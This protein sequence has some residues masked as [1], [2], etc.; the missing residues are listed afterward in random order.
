[1]LFWLSLLLVLCIPALES[2]T[3]DL[4]WLLP[5]P[6]LQVLP[7]NLLCFINIF[8][9]HIFHLLLADEWGNNKVE[10]GTGRGHKLDDQT[11]KVATAAASSNAIIL[12]ADAYVS[13]LNFGNMNNLECSRSSETKF[14]VMNP[15]PIDIGDDLF[16]YVG[17]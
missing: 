16:Q 3:K 1:M 14:C 6:V 15:K 2:G 5:P 7:F 13:L 12:A 10:L 17:L 8:L 4:L 11:M 9:N